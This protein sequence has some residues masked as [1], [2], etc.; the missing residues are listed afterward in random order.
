[1]VMKF[2]GTSVEDAAAI[3]RLIGI[4]QSRGMR[5]QWCGQCAGRVTDQL[6]EAGR[7]AARGVWVRVSRRS[8]TSMFGTNG[9][10]IRWWE[11][12]L[13][14]P[15]IASCE[16]TSG[17]WS[18]CCWNGSAGKVDLKIAGRLLGFGEVF[19]SRLVKDAL[20]EACRRM[21]RT[22]TRAAVSSPMPST[23]R[24]ILSGT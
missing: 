3:R 16:R 2:G 1:M 11:A 4:V 19:S 17:P 7:A 22:S 20:C 15:W 9:W 8:A 24:P 23:A 21:R 10:R 14:G 6:L 13:T 5:N 12:P 18:R